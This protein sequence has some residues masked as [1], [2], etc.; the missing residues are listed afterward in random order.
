VLL[1]GE[2]A[3]ERED[4]EDSGRLDTR[5]GSWDVDTAALEQDTTSPAAQHSGRTLRSTTR[6]NG[7]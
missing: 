2:A 5:L 6:T 4:G 7:E 1:R 3:V